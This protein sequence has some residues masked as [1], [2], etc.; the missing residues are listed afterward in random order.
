VVHPLPNSGA[1][2]AN[3]ITP[4]HSPRWNRTAP[5]YHARLLRAAW[6]QSLALS[7]AVC[8]AC[9]EAAHGP[10]AG[11]SDIWT[12]SPEV[13]LSPMRPVPTT[14]DAY[15]EAL[16]WPLANTEPFTSAGHL[17]EQRVDV[18]VNAAAAPSYRSL[19]TDTVFPEGAALAELPHGATGHGLAM[20]KISGKWS[21]FE[22]DA[23]GRMLAS[24]SLALCAACHA[25]APADSVFGLPRKP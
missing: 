19:V 25:Q 20:R 9:A 2:R 17:P 4:P 21:Y 3:A 14:W 12:N 5:W 7:S 22:L 6:P 16:D 11:A 23:Q 18:R 15:S 13:A 1:H 10:L 8:L 24:G